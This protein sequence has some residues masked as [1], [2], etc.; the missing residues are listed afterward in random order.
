MAEISRLSYAELYDSA[1]SLSASLI[2]L[3]IQKADR[4]AT[5]L[6][7]SPALIQSYYGIWRAGATIVPAN[8]MTRAPELQKLIFDAGVKMVIATTQTLPEV[9]QAAEGLDI[10]VAVVSLGGKED[11]D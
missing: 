10:P 11:L 3:G 9:R 7:N 6:P 1:M 2:E 4:I 5:V 8:P